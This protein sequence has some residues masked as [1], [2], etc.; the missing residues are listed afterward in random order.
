[1]RA[2]ARNEAAASGHEM[3]TGASQRP[4]VALLLLA[5]GTASA[6]VAS[7]AEEGHGLRSALVDGTAGRQLRQRLRQNGKKKDQPAGLN[8]SQLSEIL[9]VSCLKARQLDPNYPCKGS[10]E[11]TDEMLEALGK[12]NWT[13]A[14]L[15]LG[16]YPSWRDRECHSG[17]HLL[18]DPAETLKDEAWVTV[19]DAMTKF[20]KVGTSVTCGSFETKMHA[21]RPTEPRPF[22]LGVAI[23][24]G[25]GFRREDTDAATLQKFGLYVLA[26]W[27][28][29]AAYNGIKVRTEVK[30]IYQQ[31]LPVENCPDSAVLI[32]LPEHGKAFLSSPSCEFICAERGGPQVV[33][34]VEDALLQGKPLQQ[35]VVAGVQAV[36]DVLDRTGSMPL[37]MTEPEMTMNRRTSLENR[38]WWEHL[39]RT[40]VFWIWSQRV[41]FLV[42]MVFT[43]FVLASFAYFNCL[44]QTPSLR[45]NKRGR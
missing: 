34:A 13:N 8:A 36:S 45:N 39:K 17:G 40:D 29:L 25:N 26:N 38:K 2:W 18:C 9:T 1:M 11:I 24:S 42:L 3:M 5:A 21:A 15:S 28:L 23:A 33:A 31:F 27:E 37:S 32:V 35:A 4:F 41:L 19:T 43:I 6:V 44:P 12:T 22:H 14:P 10:E 7:A 16:N 30:A 20:E